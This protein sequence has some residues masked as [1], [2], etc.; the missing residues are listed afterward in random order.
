[1]GY[2]GPSGR[3]LLLYALKQRQEVGLADISPDDRN[4]DLLAVMYKELI[5]NHQSSCQILG[6]RSPQCHF[7]PAQHPGAP[8]FQRPCGSSP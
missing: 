5:D 8:A 4:K 2:T 6:H 7:S 3:V 1:M